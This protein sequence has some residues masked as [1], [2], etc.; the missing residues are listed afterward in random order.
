MI[1]DIGSNGTNLVLTG[2]GSR[3]RSSDC[4]DALGQSV[5]GQVSACNAFAFYRL[6]NAE[7]A[8]GTAEGPAD[9]QVAGW[10]APARPLA[11]SR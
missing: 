3:E 10:A 5:I 1:I 7:I 9:R 6:A 8:A 2:P 11:T 4:V